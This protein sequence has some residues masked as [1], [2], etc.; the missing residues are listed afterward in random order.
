MNPTW[1]T[2]VMPVH[3]GQ[4]FLPATLES[5]ARQGAE[6]VEFILLD[7]SDDLDASR[8]ILVNFED[9]LDIRWVD[10]RSQPSWT[11]KT[12]RGVELAG[13]AHVCMLHQDDLWLDGQLSAVRAGML[14]NPEACL[15]IAPSIFI[16]P[17][18]R[19]IGQ[20]RLP[21]APGW[22]SSDA[23]TSTL[24]VQNTI[25]IPAAV[26]RRDAWVAVRGLNA[27]LW[28]TAD[29]DLYLKLA[30]LGPVFVRSAAT[31]GFRIH[32]NSLTMSGSRDIADFRRQL[33]AVVSDHIGNVPSSRRKPVEKL[34]R[35]SLEI[36]CFLAAVAQGNRASVLRV[37]SSIFNLGPLAMLR[38]V[39][40][41]RLL[42]RLVPRLRM[43][44]S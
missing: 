24:L 44:L 17:D 30:G 13:A 33:E 7:S 39:Q 1:L 26:V 20:W 23:F 28:Y 43:R 25:A 4:R 31:T 5:A 11:Q 15:S 2:A 22:I 35:A 10:S 21:F 19:P 32:E 14:A 8:R 38:L 36:N 27:D 37:L 34:A 3:N 42:D 9:R 29:W 12:N 40:Q 41:S 16:D 18:G 6:G